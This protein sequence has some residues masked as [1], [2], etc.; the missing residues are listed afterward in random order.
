MST[1]QL[2]SNV[3]HGMPSILQTFARDDDA[4]LKDFCAEQ[5]RLP[6][7]E[8]S[9]AFLSQILVHAVS[10]GAI[11]CAGAALLHGADPDFCLSEDGGS[12]L[13]QVAAMQGNIAMVSFHA[14]LLLCSI[15]CR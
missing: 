14:R 3:S 4:G 9:R 6:S 15:L 1:L 7:T 13:L 12:S 5:F 10:A 8:S 11:R 2:L